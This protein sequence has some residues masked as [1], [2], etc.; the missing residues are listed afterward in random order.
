MVTQQKI[1]KIV[2]G[3]TPSIEATVRQ[4]DSEGAILTSVVSG[5]A[6]VTEAFD[7]V[8]V[9]QTDLATETYTFKI[10]GAGGTVVNTVAVEYTDAGRTLLKSVTKT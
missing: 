2:D 4:V 1:T 5:G 6:L 10:G 7:Y 8:S 9:E 3:T